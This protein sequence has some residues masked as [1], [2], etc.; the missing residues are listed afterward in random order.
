MS[1]DL[2]MLRDSVRAMFAKQAKSVGSGLPGTSNE[3][4]SELELLGMTGVGVSEALG[5]S[6][7]TLTDAA[8]LVFEV[9]R[10]AAAVPLAETIM[11]AHWLDAIGGWRWTGGAETVALLDPAHASCTIDADELVLSGSV[12]AVPWGRVA[13]RIIVVSEVGG[14]TVQAAIDP[15]Q[16]DVVQF[17]DIA[18]E[19]RDNIRLDG[20]RLPRTQW[21]VSA[22]NR[23]A[24]RRRGALARTVAMAGVMTAVFDLTVHYAGAREQ[25]G[26]PIGRFQ[27]VQQL[28]ARMTGE[29]AIAITAARAAVDAVE[30]GNGALATVTAKIRVS[31]SATN[32]AR[33]AHQIHGAIGVTE[34]YRLQLL[35]NRLWCWRDE[36]G[37]EA[38]WGAVLATSLLGD[39]SSLWKTV[40]ATTSE[41]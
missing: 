18:S 9:G 7:G 38:E 23:E 26:K 21:T 8:T 6:G 30:S 31:R 35:T 36:F 37:T 14:R 4:W 3:A 25:F 22:V 19:P 39:A 40:T 41:G 34:E 13:Q 27:A 1:S 20:L 16:V 12:S 33:L 15:S 24:V 28:L 10:H 29:V 17:D 2:V 11:L 5:G 32:V